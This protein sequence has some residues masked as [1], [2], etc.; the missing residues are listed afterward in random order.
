MQVSSKLC[1]SGKQQAT[2]HSSMNSPKLC[3][4]S[5][6]YQWFAVRN[7][8][9]VAY[10][11]DIVH[12]AVKLK[13]RLLKPSIVL[14]MGKFLAGVHD[15]RLVQHTFGKDLHGM[16]ERD[17]SHKDKQN[18]DAVLHITSDSVMALLAQITDAKGTTAYL[19]VIKCVVDS[20]LDKSLDPLTR[21]EK[22]WFAVFFLHYWHCWLLQSPNYTFGSNFITLNAYVCIELNAHALITFLMTIRES[23]CE[24]FLPW[25][26]G[27]QSCEK[28]FRSARSMTSIFSTVLNFSMLGLLRRLHRLHAQSC[29]ESESAETGIKYPRAEAHKLKDGHKK[30]E[31]RFE[32]PSNEDIAKTVE[33]ARKE[34]QKIVETLGMEK[35]IQE[36][37]CWENPPIPTLKEEHMR[38]DDKED[39]D[40]AEAVTDDEVLPQLLEETST[41][42]DADDIATGIVELTKVGII[43]KGLCDH[44]SSL[45]KSAFKRLSSAGLPIYHV[46]EARK[47]TK[48]K[49]SPF[50][51]I[52]HNGKSA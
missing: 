9:S 15:L 46:D 44:L 45:H 2:C 4:P 48:A 38:E 18:F 30:Q 8:T 32:L 49:F 14:P 41:A 25:M 17:V 16:R 13:A 7:A 31:H 52:S 34:A 28:V 51:E 26:L 1:L 47:S 33:K 6:W 21:L 35:L 42:Q 40:D 11:Q 43:D 20:Y 3:I 23:N 22:A 10:V 36:K 29:L 24:S 12:V 39:E 37:K 27:S 19:S 50:V 5:K